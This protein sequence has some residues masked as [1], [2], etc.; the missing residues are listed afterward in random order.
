[1]PTLLIVSIIHVHV[2][3]TCKTLIFNVVHVVVPKH[4]KNCSF[5]V[6]KLN[7]SGSIVSC[8]HKNPKY[9]LAAH[10]ANFGFLSA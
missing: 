10:K 3:P 9:F 4:S 6:E 8:I 1:V 7:V 2:K 5:V